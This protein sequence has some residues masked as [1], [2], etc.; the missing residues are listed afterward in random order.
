[1]PFLTFNHSISN[2]N[3]YKNSKFA[4]NPWQKNRRSGGF[5]T[6]CLRSKRTLETQSKHIG[7]DLT[8]EPQG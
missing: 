1:M 5:C 8:I 2:D 3:F 4:G 7:F 6:G